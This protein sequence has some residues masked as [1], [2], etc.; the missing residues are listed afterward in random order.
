MEGVYNIIPV[1]SM[2]TKN[3]KAGVRLDMAV[4]PKMGRKYLCLLFAYHLQSSIRVF[5]SV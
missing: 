2:N 4:R 5:E 1:I 3:V